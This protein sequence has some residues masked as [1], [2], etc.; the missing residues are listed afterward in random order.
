M[1]TLGNKTIKP[2]HN[3]SNFIKKPVML[4]YSI[5]G[6][7]C[8]YEINSRGIWSSNLMQNFKRNLTGFSGLYGFLYAE[9]HKHE[10]LDQGNLPY[11][12]N[13]SRHCLC[14]TRRKSHKL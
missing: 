3:F 13:K 12:W 9:H 4:M 1:F 14:G 6:D 2:Y 11:D 8:P 10:D 5:P 7:N